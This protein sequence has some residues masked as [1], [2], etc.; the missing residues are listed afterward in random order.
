MK[1][2]VGCADKLKTIRRDRVGLEVR[3]CGGNQRLASVRQN[4][5]ELQSVLPVRVS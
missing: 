2:I 5:N 1:Q 3:P 4:Q